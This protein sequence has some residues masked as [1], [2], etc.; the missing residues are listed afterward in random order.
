MPE[1]ESDEKS[2]LISLR[3]KLTEFAVNIE[4]MKLAE[5][6]ELLNRPLR[7]MYINFIAGLARGIGIA[8]GFTVL[9]A[10]V[11][12]FLRRLVALNLPLIGNFI[13][14]IVYTVQTQLK[15]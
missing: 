3:G 1:I 2:L 9:G 15:P 14:E 7:L 5:Y 11:V 8:V 6:V 12:I 13:A 4:K 10:I